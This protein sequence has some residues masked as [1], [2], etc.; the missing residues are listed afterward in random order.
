ME[1]SPIDFKKG[2][3]TVCTN[4]VFLLDASGSMSG[5]R[6]SQLNYAMQ[7]TL[8]V[9]VE[10]GLKNETEI[11]VRVIKF[12]SGLDWVIGDATKGVLVDDAV[13]MWKDLEAAGGTDTAGAIDESLKAFKTEYFGYRNKKPIVILVTDGESNDPQ[14]T[15]RSVDKLKTAM[16]GN[17]GKEKIVRIAVGVEDHNEAE[18]N[19]F[20]SLGN[21]ID[22]SGERNNVPLVFGVSDATAIAKV[23]KNVAVSSLYSV[24]GAG[25]VALK[26]NDDTS[27]DQEEA[28]VLAIDDTPIVIENTTETTE[29]W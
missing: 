13:R 19:Y 10:E 8:N 28:A 29:T 1:N 18:L 24:G 23:I 11:F 3:T 15:K 4:L 9:L 14:E 12:N 6:I 22:D 16:S 21:I 27:N 17:T 2:I 5:E 20:A 7:E 26:D 25:A